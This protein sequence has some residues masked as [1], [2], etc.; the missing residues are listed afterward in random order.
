[1][2]A[3]VLAVGIYLCATVIMDGYHMYRDAVA[4][5]SLEDKVAS[6]RG[7]ENYSRD[8]CGRGAVGGGPQVL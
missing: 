2:A 7:K 8:L 5:V 3:V 6:I 4:E 1:M